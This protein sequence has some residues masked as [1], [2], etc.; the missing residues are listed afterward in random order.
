MFEFSR[1]RV[2]IFEFESSSNWSVSSSN[3]LG[4]GHVYYDVTLI[5]VGTPFLDVLA[6]ERE[7]SERVF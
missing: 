7:V 6:P 3:S 2:Y 1:V 4:L 5:N